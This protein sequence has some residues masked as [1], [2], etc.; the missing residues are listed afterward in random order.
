[1]TVSTPEQINKRVQEEI[2]NLTTKLEEQIEILLVKKAF[3]NEGDFNQEIQIDQREISEYSDFLINRVF[4]KYLDLGWDI[5]RKKH[6]FPWE[7]F[8][9]F[10]PKKEQK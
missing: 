10:K 8:Y 4:D 9:A 1:M 5:K 2:R 6:P 3:N 7:T